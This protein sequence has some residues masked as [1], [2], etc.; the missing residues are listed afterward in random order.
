MSLFHSEDDVRIEEDH[1]L[2]TAQRELPAV[3]RL[4][5]LAFWLHYPMDHLV[6]YISTMMCTLHISLEDV[7]I[8]KKKSLH[9]FEE[10][11]YL[12]Q[13]INQTQVSFIGYVMTETKMS[14]KND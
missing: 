9:V 3:S 6:K 14:T 2:I 10:R 4:Y 8:E 5:T 1:R 12:N 13:R 11:E 7:L